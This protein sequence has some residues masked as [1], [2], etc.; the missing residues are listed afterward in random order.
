MT[1]AFG[2]L[3][4]RGNPNESRSARGRAVT[5]LLLI[6]TSISFFTAW[7]ARD[8][9]LIYRL[10]KIAE[11]KPVELYNEQLFCT[12]LT[13]CLRA[14][15]KV[16][17]TGIRLITEGAVD[18]LY[19]MPGSV[20]TDVP[21]WAPQY[22]RNVGPYLVFR[23]L[24]LVALALALYRYFRHWWTVALVANIL[25]WWSTG[26]P[27][28]AFV[29][30]YGNVVSILGDK[31]LGSILDY[32]FSM[33]STIFL[34]EYDYLAL[35]LLL[36]FPIWLRNSRIHQGIWRPLALG[37]V[38]AMTFEHLA[39]VYVVALVWLALRGQRRDWF[40]PALLI[41]A[42]W[43]V[44]IV[45]MIVNTRLAVPGAENRIVTITQLGYRINREGEHEWIIFRFVFGFL[46]VPY[47]LGRLFGTIANR[48]GLLRDAVY[49][50]QPY[51]NSVL[52]GLCLSYLVG[53]FHSALITEF[54]RQTIAAQVLLFCS[55]VLCH[56]SN[57][58]A[59]RSV[60]T[61]A[62]PV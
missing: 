15:H 47:I 22:V 25:L 18:L 17:L 40:R 10:S 53:F 19:S 9:E 45:A 36:F 43:L 31:D 44:Y 21:T 2:G 38:L 11:D 35:A 46:G 37:F 54:G 8:H 49:S 32:H 57:S 3:S 58:P 13:D 1:E 5:V 20:V 33:N 14:S 60:I 27:I 48:L 50:L 23:V 30:M 42:S 12:T 62:G 39:V 59:R 61:A 7:P 41:S 52:I 34:L 24:V 4:I 29:R 6:V 51:I 56:P 28:R 55:G 16:A 26:A